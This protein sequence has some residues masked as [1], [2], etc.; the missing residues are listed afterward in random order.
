MT[1]PWQAAHNAQAQSNGTPPPSVPQ[2]EAATGLAGAYADQPSGIFAGSGGAG[3]SLMNKTHPVG[4][5]RTG[6]V[7]K[8]PY[9]RQSTN[10]KGEPKFWQQGSNQPVTNAVDAAGQPNRKVMD[11]IVELDTEYQMDAQ[12]AAM[13]NREAPFEGGRRSITLAGDKLKAFIKAV[14]AYNASHPTAPITGD[15]DMVG[16]RVTETRVATKPN[17]NGG[18]PIKIHEY[19]IADA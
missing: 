11:T 15:P 10:Q 9:L 6:I 2:T 12:E 3:P 13:L 8:P 14:Q 16:K 7:A 1:D 18:D 19:Q 17:P 4:T 5:S